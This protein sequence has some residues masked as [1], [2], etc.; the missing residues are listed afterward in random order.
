MMRRSE[1]NDQIG[2]GGVKLVLDVH[3]GLQNG[4]LRVGKLAESNADT[5][6]QG[7]TPWNKG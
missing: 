3:T 2:I 4:F 1:D 5:G 6:R 7:I